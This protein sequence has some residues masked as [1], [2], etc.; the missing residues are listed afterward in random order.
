[1]TVLDAYAVVAYLRGETASDDV[2]AL[3]RSPTWLAAVNAAEVM[4]QLVRVDG[5]D[6]DEVEIRLATLRIDGMTVEPAA[7]ELAIVAGA[8]RAR[9]YHRSTRAVSLADCFAAATALAMD[10]PLATADPHLLDL[11][12]CENGTVRPLPPRGPSD[13][14]SDKPFTACPP[15]APAGPLDRRYC[16]VPRGSPTM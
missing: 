11:M 9:H 13:A 4:D 5:Q 3:L 10:Q 14:G 2:E 12:R 6:P 1:M 8:L 16:A 7:E 15:A